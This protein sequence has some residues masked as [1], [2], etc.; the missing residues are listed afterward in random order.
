MNEQ[1]GKKH[2]IMPLGSLNWCR[3]KS[4]VAM[5]TAIIPIVKTSTTATAIT[6]TEQENH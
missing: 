3:H 6:D 5:L 2:Y 4:K 1:T